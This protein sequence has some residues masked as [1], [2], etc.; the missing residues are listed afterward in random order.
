MKTRIYIPSDDALESLIST[1]N[2]SWE[3][4]ADH[5]PP[6]VGIDDWR[7]LHKKKHW[8]KFYS[9]YELAVSWESADPFLPREIQAWFGN[10]AELLA[11]IPEHKTPL[12]GGRRP[13]QTD[14]L[15]FI[16]YGGVYAVAVEGKAH[17]SFGP[18]V[19]EWRKDESAG[20]IERL[21]F[22]CQTLGLP[23]PPANEIRYQLLHRT[24]SAVIEAERFHADC[25]AMFVHSFAY[26]QPRETS[27]SFADFL[28]FLKL[29]NISLDDKNPYTGT[30]N[31]KP[32]YFA[33]VSPQQ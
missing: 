31:G 6:S 4:I 12:P 28:S 32:L 33:W 11:V 30:E 23:Y 8:R 17:E 20:K 18:T 22:I 16:R 14:A 19:G 26:K 13:S 9:A 1:P 3:K 27:E 25:A 7:K 24:A 15:A 5:Y 21:K 29:F 2:L 10:S